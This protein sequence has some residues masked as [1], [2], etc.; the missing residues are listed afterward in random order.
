MQFGATVSGYDL[1]VLNEREVRAG[2]GILFFISV[3]VFA[4]AWYD[5]LM[6]PAQMMIIAFF[7]DFLIRVIAPHYAPSLI[8]GRFAVQQQQPEYVAAA[9]KRFAWGIGLALALF[10]VVTLIF[11]KQMSGLNFAVCAICIVL[12]FMESAFGICLGCVVYHRLLK[13]PLKLCPGGYCEVD[14]KD[15]LQQLQGQQWG[16]LL[17]FAVAMYG[18][19]LFLQSDHRNLHHNGSNHAFIQE[20]KG[21]QPPP[22]LASETTTESRLPTEPAAPAQTESGAVMMEHHHH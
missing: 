22:P 3:V 8:L 18:S 5:D 11:L 15:P 1:P 4:G 14:K 17:L 13:Q 10:M 12:L 19:L 21:N 7:I 16:A 9:P 6:L 20:L 2:A